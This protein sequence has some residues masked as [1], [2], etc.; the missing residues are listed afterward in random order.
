MNCRDFDFDPLL[1]VA[2]HQHWLL[3]PIYEKFWS[4]MISSASMWKH[5]KFTNRLI[6]TTILPFPQWYLYSSGDTM[7]Y[8]K[9]IKDHMKR[10]EKKTKLKVQEWDFEKSEHVAHFR[11]FPVVYSKRVDSVLSRVE[12]QW[13]ALMQALAQ[14][15]PDLSTLPTSLKRKA[16]PKRSKSGQRR[17]KHDTSQ[18]S[19]DSS[20]PPTPTL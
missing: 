11:A 12:D 13:R 9:D 10:I 2:N 7:I 1:Q 19:K 4:V 8:A 15:T 17:F 6:D 14:E 18:K 16:K 5:F 20:A 3:T